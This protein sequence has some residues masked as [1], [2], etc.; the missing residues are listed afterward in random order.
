MDEKLKIP[1]IPTNIPD[2]LKPASDKITLTY[3]QM[4]EKLGLT[5]LSEQTEHKLQ[6]LRENFFN[7]KETASF[8]ETGITDLKNALSG[9]GKSLKE[10]A[11]ENST[12]ELTEK[13]GEQVT[14]LAENAKDLANNANVQQALQTGKDGLTKVQTKVEETAKQL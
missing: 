3:D 4:K 12:Q 11:R 6:I 13:T 7:T 1:E 10:I 2:A 14:K 5:D 8:T 9:K